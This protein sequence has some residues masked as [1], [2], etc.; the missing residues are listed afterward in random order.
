MVIGFI[1]ISGEGSEKTQK[2]EYTITIKSKFTQWGLCCMCFILF[3]FLCVCS[4]SGA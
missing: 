2:L 3:L 1:L 4:N